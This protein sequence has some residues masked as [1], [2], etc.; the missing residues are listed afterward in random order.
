MNSA[1]VFVDGG[2]FYDALHA[3]ACSVD[4]DYA[5]LANTL[6]A[7]AETT[8][9]SYYMSLI[10]AEPYPARTRHHRAVL[11]MVRSQ[12]FEVRT[13]RTEVVY[14]AFIERG[15]EALMSTDIV[16]TATTTDVDTIVLV[17]QRPELLP[18]VEAAQAAG[19]T[20][21]V[22]YFVNRFEPSP[23]ELADAADVF[24][25]I[26]VDDILALPL[27]G[28]TRHRVVGHAASQLA[29]AGVGQTPP[30]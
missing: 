7:P 13:G 26:T 19:K 22:A 4:I 17:S 23:S 2:P 21:R 24:T 9:M 27:I 1:S 12:G 3:R 16:R 10:P 20:V 8:A 15:V 29:A 14:S 25:E 11:D 18:A 5:A 30:E 6:A 28:P